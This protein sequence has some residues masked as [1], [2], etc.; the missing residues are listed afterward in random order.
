[1]SSSLGQGIQ[2]TFS[3]ASDDKILMTTF[4][5]DDLFQ[6]IFFVMPTPPLITTL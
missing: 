4:I 2:V 1:M 6:G 3:E 5:S